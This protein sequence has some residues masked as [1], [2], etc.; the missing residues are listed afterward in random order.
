[1]P[2]PIPSPLYSMYHWLRTSHLRL[3]VAGLVAIGLIASV[4]IFAADTKDQDIAKVVSIGDHQDPQDGLTI[5]QD[6]KMRYSFK[7]HAGLKQYNLRV[8]MDGQAIENRRWDNPNGASGTQTHGYDFRYGMD[9][10]RT[11]RTLGF[12][13]TLLR[14]G[15]H[16][17]VVRVCNNNLPSTDCKDRG[18]NPGQLDRTQLNFKI[19]DKG[20]GQSAKAIS[21]GF[22]GQPVSIA[23]PAN[24]LFAQNP[25]T[26]GGDPRINM[27]ASSQAQNDEESDPQGGNEVEPGLSGDELTGDNAGNS[28][29]IDNTVGSI[30]NT[31]LASTG[32]TS[33][34][35]GL[36]KIETAYAATHSITVQVNPTG[37][38]PGF[39]SVEISP[40]NCSPSNQ[41]VP[42]SGIVK[43]DGC[44]AGNHSA[45]AHPG[46]FKNGNQNCT[47]TVQSA[48]ANN[49]AQLY[50]GCIA[51]AIPAP[52]PPPPPPPGPPAP[53]PGG[54]TAQIKVWV[55]PIG[56]TAGHV[57]VTVQGPC[58]DHKKTVSSDGYVI[59][60]GCDVG[61]SYTVSVPA[62][63]TAANGSHWAINSGGTSHT[64]NNLDAG[65]ANNPISWV[66]TFGYDNTDGG[67]GGGGGAGDV[68]KKP[69]PIMA[70]RSIGATQ[71]FVDLFKF[72]AGPDFNIGQVK[73][74]KAIV[75]GQVTDDHVPPVPPIAGHGFKYFPT[76]KNEPLNLGN[77]GDGNAHSVQLQAFATNGTSRT[78]TVNVAAAAG[79]PPTG[80][81]KG[82]IAAL[83]FNDQNGN[84]VKD[85]GENGIP[86]V[87]VTASI[88]VSNN[89]PTDTG[90]AVKTNDQGV[91]TFTDLPNA[92]YQV[93]ASPPSGYKAT[94]ATSQ[95]VTVQGNTV[96]VGFGEQAVTPATASPTPTSTPAPSSS[97][98]PT[99]PGTG[100]NPP[101][102]L[103]GAPREKGGAQTQ[104]ASG[105]LPSTGQAGLIAFLTFLVAS[106]LYYGGRKFLNKRAKTK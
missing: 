47:A 67:G 85:N 91:V 90:V 38:T 6:F 72:G 79:T 73:Q 22:Q 41:N 31:N 86:N 13:W 56:Q 62:Q 77:I 92:S 59:F 21:T 44:A 81:D 12:D 52:P 100:N 70:L 54:Q 88:K 45:I 89:T 8:V 32:S 33:K 95:D 50:Y 9:A 53:G 25:V 102:S 103:P 20:S 1:M 104:S 64:L 16:K 48:P 15:N 78:I 74:V 98:T 30:L 83:V 14:P 60:G 46:A 61:K 29:A 5:D 94:T 96:D 26:N 23:N 99:T 10:Q 34:T 87:G 37:L 68:V 17:L 69:G 58:T 71:A 19:P 57:D 4:S 18:G 27:P 93:V 35:N 43:F 28:N 82:N 40:A 97:A 106:G 24:Q 80:A 76:I 101:A 65:T 49:S 36:F 63:F 42:S 2:N 75:D 39:V 66:P 55:N 105:K 3:L 84:G 11:T 51:D 7:P